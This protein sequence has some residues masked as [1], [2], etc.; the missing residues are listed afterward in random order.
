M[1]MVQLGGGGPMINQPL[2]SAV[3]STSML[4]RAANGGRDQQFSEAIWDV[5]WSAHLPMA[6]STD[7]VVVE[8]STIERARAFFAQNLAAIVEEDPASTPFLQNG[9]SDAKTRYLQRF[10]D[11]FEFKDGDR[12]AG[13]MLC[14]PVDWSTYYIRLT[15][16]LPEYHG[17]K[18][19]QRF[20]PKL[21]EV[22]KDAGVERIETDTSPSNLAVMHIMN[23]FRFNVTGTILSERWGA[24]V[25]FTKFLDEESE[26]VFL[27]QFC[28][29]I[30]YQA[31][32]DRSNAI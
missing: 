17:K 5:D 28:T 18:L 21:F 7:G 31:R 23:R 2:V 14:T 20:L 24:L 32:G 30:R 8:Y 16:I 3:A 11:C 1:G 26:G 25:R 12:T 22:L 10:G 27:R 4:P 15:A 6:L 29:G 9:A 19:P 13:F